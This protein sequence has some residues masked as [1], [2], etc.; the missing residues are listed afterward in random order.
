MTVAQRN[1]L[2][3]E[4][5]RLGAAA[6]SPAAA[7]HAGLD[8]VFR[9]TSIA[10]VGASRV[11]GSIGAE[12]LHNVMEHGFTGVVYPVNARADS[13]QSVKAYPSV[14]DIPGSVDLAIIVV[15]APF[16]P[17]VLEECG[18][19]GVKAA[20]VISAGFKETG[21]AGAARELAI[22]GCARRY[23]M[24]LIGPNCLGVLNTEPGVMLDAT[25]APSF[26]PHGR[27]AFSS[28]SG[29]LGL[30]ILDYA[31]ELNVGISHFV[32]IGNKADVS[33]SDLLEYW[34]HDP[35]VGVI[36]LYLES[37]G[38]PRRFAAVAR[39]VARHKPVI[40]VKSGRTAAGVRAAASH[41]GSLAGSDV[42]VDALCKQTGVIRTETIEELFDVG[43][44]LAH[45]PVPRG[46]RVGLVTNSGG[47]AI[48]ASDACE[49]HDLVVPALDPATTAALKSLLVPEASVRNPV[50]MIA[51]ATPEAYERAVQLMLADPNIDS[52]LAIYVTPI[53]TRPL[54]VAQAIVRGAHA[55]AEALKQRGLPPK[56]VLTCFMGSH[57]VPDGLRSLQEGNIPSFMFPESAAI[58][59][60]RAAAYGRGLM[61]REGKPVMF[62]DVDRGRGDHAIAAARERIAGAGCGNCAT[63]GGCGL[64]TSANET[65]WLEPAE[66]REL[67][68]AYGLRT[69]DAALA[70]T[71]DETAKEAAR[72][73]FPVAIKLSSKTI[74]HKSDVGGVVLNVG[75]EAEARRA[76]DDISHQLGVLGRG[77]EMEGVLVQ[78][79]VRD[80][81][82]AI[83]GV[84]R[85]PSFG[86][87][88]M[89]GLG[90]VHVEILRDVAFR[91]H[92]LTDVDAEELVR[93]VKSFKLLEGYRGA[94][95]ADIAAL[96]EA[97]L[98]VSRLLDDHPEILELDLNPIKALAPGHG[99][100][101]VDARVSIGREV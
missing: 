4:G 55:G 11:R 44:L 23:G 20:V 52:L 1:N 66:V 5:A 38:N 74:T 57:G 40:A 90:G 9:P 83:I 45:Q 92:P 101:V 53:V 42:A 69:P 68:A 89:F 32:S 36:L 22:I 27:V 71:A 65:L 21:P 10:I 56:P 6:G 73:G 60:A 15:P 46:N 51:S 64:E 18:K 88:V 99:C 79:M 17:G 50:D 80:G 61:R 91:I 84:T 77:S 35:N 62:A 87:I 96:E 93:E 97:L 100:V 28:Q 47:P 49:S 58:A 98:R 14:L 12:I 43:M 75:S 26:P 33:G 95:P 3:I 76:F 7:S 2:E 63:C 94:P 25:F 59:L 34:E 37:F 48:M 81:V 30:A 24:R 39:R 70:C 82:E 72:M 67:L 41:T 29:A 86:P 85:E 19:K 78:P 8:A 31:I 16:V 54:D 13:V